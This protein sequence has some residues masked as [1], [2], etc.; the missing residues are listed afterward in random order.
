VGGA[1][2]AV[3]PRSADER[4]HGDGESR[5]NAHGVGPAGIEPA[6]DGL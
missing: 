6:T 4:G 5:S 2:V 1:V 3:A